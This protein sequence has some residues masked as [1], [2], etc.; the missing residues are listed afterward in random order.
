MLPPLHSWGS[1]AVEEKTRAW[2]ESYA[3]EIGY[4]VR[5]LYIAADGDVG[6]CSFVYH[7]S[8]ALVAGNEVDMWVRATPGFRRR[9]GEWLIVHDHESVPFDPASGQAL[10]DLRP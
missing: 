6:F 3:G 10:V 4:E 5:D 1:E 2:F 7:V 9:D 8:G